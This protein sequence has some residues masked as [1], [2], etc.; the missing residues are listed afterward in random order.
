MQSRPGW[1]TVPLARSACGKSWLILCLLLLNACSSRGGPI[2]YEVQNFGVP[3]APRAAAPNEAYRIAT[4]D[5]LQMVVFNVEALSREYRVDMAGNL[6]VPLI[7]QVS[8]VGK[9]TEELRAI[10][11][12]PQRNHRSHQFDE[13]Q[14]HSR[15]RC[16]RGGAVPSHGST[17]V[18]ASCRD[19][20]GSGPPA[21]QSAAGGDLPADSGEAYGGRLRSRKHP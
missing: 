7:G 12:Q 9:T 21:G 10:S 3:D 19:V 1:G 4:G 2:P 13:Q 8:A 17:D 18:V 20:W 11:S 5:T 14:D 15:W 16:A 6:A